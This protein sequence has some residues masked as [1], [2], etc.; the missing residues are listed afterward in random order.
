MISFSNHRP[1]QWALQHSFMFPLKA[2]VLSSLL[3]NRQKSSTIFKYTV[4]QQ[5]FS[6]L[7][8]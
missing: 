7:H 4:Q 6:P 2:T 3:E 8:G 1:W 5:K